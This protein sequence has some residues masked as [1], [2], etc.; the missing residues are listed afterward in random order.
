MIIDL[1]ILGRNADVRAALLKDGW[2]LEPRERD[3]YVASHQAVPDEPTARLRLDKVGLLT[4]SKVRIRFP[5]PRL[6][7]PHS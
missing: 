6:S 4:S 2:R 5:L 3:Q 1:E 7:R